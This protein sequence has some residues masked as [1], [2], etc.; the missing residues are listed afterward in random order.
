MTDLNKAGLRRPR[1]THVDASHR[2]PFPLCLVDSLIEVAIT[3]ARTDGVSLNYFI[4]LAVSEKI[5]RLKGDEIAFE[6]QTRK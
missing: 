6:A 5:A 4:S 2:R 1:M 3:R